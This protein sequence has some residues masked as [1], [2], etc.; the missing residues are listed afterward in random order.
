MVVKAATKERKERMGMRTSIGCKATKENERNKD[1]SV[2]GAQI[3]ERKENKFADKSV[4]P[5]GPVTQSDRD[6]C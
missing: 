4:K 2:P 6:R 3:G 5:D 1:A